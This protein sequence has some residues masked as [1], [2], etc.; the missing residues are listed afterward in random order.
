MMGSTLVCLELPRDPLRQLPLEMSMVL[1]A[2]VQ[3]PLL[4]RDQI[5]TNKTAS[6]Q[7]QSRQK[8]IVPMIKT[9]Q[10]PQLPDPVNP[11]LRFT[12][13]GRLTNIVHRQCRMDVRDRWDRLVVYLLQSIIEQDPRR[14]LP[15]HH[16][17]RMYYHHILCRSDLV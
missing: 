6:I 9:G 14:P 17:I 11:Q 2:I 15:R 13:T 12:A 7:D 8:D 10:I 3:W 5:N 1:A 4:I 16:Q